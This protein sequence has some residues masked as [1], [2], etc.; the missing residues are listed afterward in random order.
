MASYLLL[1]RTWIFIRLG[2]FLFS[3]FL[4]SLRRFEGLGFLFEGELYRVVPFSDRELLSRDTLRLRPFEFL[5]TNEFARSS[6]P[7][8]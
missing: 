8:R 4:F 7:P 5:S 6:V 1:R 2:P 3:L